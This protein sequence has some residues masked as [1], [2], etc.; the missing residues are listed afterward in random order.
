MNCSAVAATSA[1]WSPSKLLFSYSALFSLL[2]SSKNSINYPQQQQLVQYTFELLPPFYRKGMKVQFVLMHFPRISCLL[3]SPLAL[4]QHFDSILIT[5]HPVL[6]SLWFV[7][8]GF[9]HLPPHVILIIAEFNYFTNCFGCFLLPRNWV[10]CW[11]WQAPG[12]NAFYRNEFFQLMVL[13]KDGELNF[14]EDIA[15]AKR[16]VYITE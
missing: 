9:W 13:M 10:R 8:I 7:S 1:S 6:D 16:S 11:W 3:I 2:F 5:F 15:W 12:D 14:Y 4:F